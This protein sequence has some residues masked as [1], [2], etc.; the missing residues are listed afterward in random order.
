MYNT[1]KLTRYSI[2]VVLSLAVAFLFL[3]GPNALGAGKD[4][5]CSDADPCTFGLVCQAGTCAGDTF[6]LGDLTPDTTPGAESGLSLGNQGLQETI[7]SLINVALSLL[8]IVA[9]V[10]ILA[11]GFMWMTAGGNDEKVAGARKLI[12]SGIIGLAI[13]LSAWAVTRFVFSALQ[14]ATGSGT[15]PSGFNSPPPSGS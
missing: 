5:A 8:G 13:I 14:S 11:G 9:V 3:V 15:L 10:I 1:I 4:E 2:A 6:G 7:A 12:F